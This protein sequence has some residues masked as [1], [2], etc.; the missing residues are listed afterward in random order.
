MKN[1]M[2]MEKIYDEHAVRLYNMSLRI[3]GDSCEAE[4]VMHDSLLQYY[5][6]KDRSG[7]VDLRKW[8]S[9][10]CIRKSIDRL[11]QKK[12]FKDF[13]DYY[14]DPIL[15]DTSCE[16]LDLD[17]G[18]IRKALSLLPD[19]YRLIL[20]LYLF[21]GYDYEEITQITGIKAVTVRTL[22]MRGRRKLAE[23]LKQRQW[24]D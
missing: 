20:S 24:T 1:S 18:N 9:C 16:D 15:D 8:L 10:V 5:G 11:R 2:D 14:E 21:E 7:I 13:L 12:K 6:M 19:N 22:Y 3:L 23:I 17:I 4:E